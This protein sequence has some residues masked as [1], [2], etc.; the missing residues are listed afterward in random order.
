MAESNLMLH[1]GARVVS[2]EELDAAPAPPPTETWFPLRHGEVLGA[3]LGTLDAAEFRV[4]RS[5]FSLSK[6]SARFFGT[7]DLSTPVSSGVTLSVGVR[8]SVDK[9]FPL[10]FCAGSRVF[11]CDNLSF[12]AELLVARKHTVNGGTRFREAIALAVQSLGQ[13]RDGEAHRIGAM[14]D[15]PLTEMHAESLIL[16]AYERDIISHRVL[17]AV[18][19]A[20]RKPPHP[21]FAEPN[22][23][24]LMNAFTGAIQGL[25]TTNPPQFALQTIRLHALLC[26]PEA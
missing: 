14:R 18:I 2:R 1:R 4:E 26:P 6:D 21:E 7:L 3:V 13:F 15:F 12:R 8:N 24:S 19:A 11:V 25:A 5:R 10:G 9:T 22:L 16:Q 23:W 17:P 20:W